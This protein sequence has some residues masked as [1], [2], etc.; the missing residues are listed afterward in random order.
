M[1]KIVELS[2]FGKV[3]DG[4]LTIRDR[5]SFDTYLLQFE[6]KDVEILVKRKKAKRSLDQNRLWW[7]YMTILSQELGYTKDEIHEICKFK[8]L[9][10]EI[11]DEKS[12]EIFKYL[13]STTTMNKLEFADLIFD[14]QKWSIETF[15]INLPSPGDQFEIL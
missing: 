3:A 1:G 5:R 6:G 2:Y 14:L 11:A 7:V 13:G 4:K 10:K 8:F 9:Q 15:N 12:G